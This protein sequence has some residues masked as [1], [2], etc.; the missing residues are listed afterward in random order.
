MSIDVLQEKIRKAKNPSVL[1]FAAAELPEVL[2]EAAPL[3]QAYGAF[4]TAM[5]EKLQGIIP[6]VRVSFGAF[7][8]MGAE[9]IVELKRVLSCAA[10]LGYYVLL[11]APQV[12]SPAAAAQ[13][14]EMLLGSDAWQCDGVIVNAYAGADV[15]RPFLPYAKSEQKSLFLLARTGNKSA[16][17]IQ[18]LM[19]GSRLVHTAMADLA[20][21]YAEGMYGKCGYSQL[22]I[23]AGAGAAESTNT[24]RRK[25]D[26]LFLLVDG[27]DYPSANAK[28]CAGA[29]D[30]FGH[31][32]AVCAG[33]AIAGAWKEEPETDYLTAA[34]HAAERM[35]KNLT[36]Y[37]TVL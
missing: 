28:K 33:S 32:A 7:A 12:C 11:E 18:D 2:T 8:L 35:K 17:E 14:A 19:T 34:L 29:F 31:G 5:L 37:V 27:Y 13:A 21:R 22:G 26:R 30:R 23:V 10:A 1:E 9:G 20:N 24:L 3:P 36:T 4:C 15:I 16:A 6:A 25:Y